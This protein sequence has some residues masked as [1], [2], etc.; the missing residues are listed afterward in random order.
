MTEDLVCSCDESVEL[1][2]ANTILLTAI[3]DAH[4]DMY[5]A[6]ERLAEAVKLTTNI[7]DRIDEARE[8]RDV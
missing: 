5:H 7:I 3:T 1:R 4:T 2:R 6:N 8:T